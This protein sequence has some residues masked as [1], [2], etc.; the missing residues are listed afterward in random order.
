MSFSAFNF[1][2]KTDSRI[3]QL[4]EENR[5]LVKKLI[6]QDILISDNKA[7][8]DQFETTYPKSSSL[9][10]ARVVGAPSFI[11]GVTSPSIFIIDKGTN[12]GVKV[13]SA[14]VV[15]NI[16]VGKIV[17]S[18]LYFSKVI[19]ATNPSLSLIVKGQRG[20]SGIIKGEGGRQML[21]DN[22]AQ[23]GDIKEGDYIVTKG[24]QNEDGT[25]TAPDLVVGKIVSIDKKPSAVF[26]KGKV[27]SPLD[28][29]ALSTVFVL[30]Y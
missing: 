30:I 1:L 23:E 17:S 21:L 7:L 8:R 26:Q 14:V 6:E 4:E 20:A 19:L 25:G 22:V 11:P 15:K 16:L 27:E 9:V 2:S 12:D 10:P 24:E 29:S 3:R 18:S 5:N 28:F 13:G